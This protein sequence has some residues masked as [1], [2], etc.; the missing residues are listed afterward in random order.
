[1]RYLQRKGRERASIDV[2][3]PFTLLLVAC[4]PFLSPAQ[5]A[6]RSG[7]AVFANAYQEHERAA[8]ALETEFLLQIELASDEERFNLYRAYD[9]FLGTWLQVERLQA[10]HAVAVEADSSVEEEEARTALRDQAQFVRLE[11]E[12]TEEDLERNAAA[13]E[14]PDRFRINQAIRRLFVEVRAAIGRL[15]SEQCAHLSCAPVS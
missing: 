9:R 2:I 3:F 14:R 8:I 15:M 10:Q 13:L 6:E 12:Q 4:L 11:L 7:D 1:L 5:G